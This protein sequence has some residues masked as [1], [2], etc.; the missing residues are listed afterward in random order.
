MTIAEQ[1]KGS[2]FILE[3]IIPPSLYRDRNE[4]L[5]SKIETE[6]DVVLAQMTAN[7]NVYKFESHE[8]LIYLFG[9]HQRKRKGQ[10]QKILE[11]TLGKSKIVDEYTS[12][13]LLKNEFVQYVEDLKHKRTLKL[14]S[15]PLKFNGY[16]GEDL[17]LFEK[18]ENWYEWQR[19]LYNKLFFKTN[20]IREPDPREIITIYD[21]DGNS[22][23]SS[24]FKYL[25]YKHPEEVGRVTYG[26]ASQLRSSLTNIGPKKIYIIDLTRSKST[27]DKPTDLISA[28][29]DLK[30][31]LVC[32][33]MYGS[34]NTML[35]NPPHIII[36][37]NYIFDLNL[38]SK[39]RWK[40][41]SIK[42]KKL[43]DVTRIIRFNER[44]KK[45]VAK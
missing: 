33:A 2:Y 8:K 11:K 5:I 17:R 19:D 27:Y 7:D 38:L 15:E 39:D 9:T 10:L 34:G 6:I 23:K 37:A 28:I 21:R 14:S 45:L 22:G 36:S 32:T 41:F 40:I 16:K 4:K 44:K 30:N 42:N 13:A 26:T 29:E 18:K 20:E 35:M 24:F 43:K 1:N 31:G 25:F 3:V 12:D